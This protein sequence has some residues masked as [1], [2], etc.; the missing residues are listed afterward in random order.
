[1]TV[2]HEISVRIVEEEYR[3]ARRIGQGFGWKF[4]DLDPSVPSFTVQVLSSIDRQSYVL[5]FA[6]DNYKEWP[7]Y[8]EFIHPETGERGTKRCYPLDSAPEGGAMFHLTP[9][10]CFPCSR[11]AYGRWQGPHPDWNDRI[12]NWVAMSGAITTLADMILMVHSRINMENSY[13][14]RME[15]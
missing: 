4:S 3:R 12:E 13:H 11:K 1:M 9:C 10:I 2:A 5:E 6:C 8:I 14:G 7:P 15:S